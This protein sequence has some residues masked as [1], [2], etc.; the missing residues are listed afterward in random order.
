MSN[1]HHATVVFSP[2]VKEFDITKLPASSELQDQYI[3]RFGI[4]D[5]RSLVISAYQR[6]VAASTQTLVIRTEF[7]TH[8]AQNALLKVL[9]EPPQSTKFVLVLPAGLQLLATIESR[10]EVLTADSGIEDE[11]FTDF[12]QS[13]Y[14]ERLSQIEVN[15]KAKDLQWQRAVKQGL[16]QYVKK[17]S[18]EMLS[19]LEFVS[20]FLLT[21]GASNKFLLEHLALT[22]PTRS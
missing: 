6:P 13:S 11:V 17:A 19:E 16:F 14:A 10:V 7:I 2:V 12:L 9:E 20:R 1:L 8:E 5:A 4:D 18:P 15:L 21:R 3:E 22:L